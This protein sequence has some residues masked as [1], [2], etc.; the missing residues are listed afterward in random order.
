MTER[1]GIIGG[2]GLGNALLAGGG[3]EAVNV[4]TPVG[5]P[6]APVVLSRWEEAPIA[7]V[8]RHGVGHTIPPS[9]VPYRANIWA[10]K[11]VGCRWVIASG[12][13]GSLREEIAPR[14][15]VI[16]DQ[17][18]D[19]THRR[20]GTFFDEPGGGAVHVECAD[21]FCEELR[22]ILM[23]AGQGL[24]LGGAR[25]HPAGTY[26]CMEGPAFSTRAESRMHRAMGGD[27][28][29]MTAQPEAKLAREAEMSYALVALA[30][31]YD[32]WKPHDSAAGKQELLREIMGHMAA[33][34]ENALAL[35]RAAAPRIWARR[36]EV[37]PAHR[38][39]ELA[40][41]TDRANIP[42]ETKKRLGLL[43]GKYV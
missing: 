12:A 36:A 40:I 11:A 28:I 29:G 26:V 38:S 43:W 10:L 14:D 21:P 2:S 17:A 13:V 20:I 6:S 22:G 8:A 1:I 15:L 32:C 30:T 19:R 25:V 16:C 9:A 41:W 7:F 3:G 23:S 42:A 5:V 27:V 4:E 18:I 35:V 33:A 34:T 37:W 39:L 24:S 31:D